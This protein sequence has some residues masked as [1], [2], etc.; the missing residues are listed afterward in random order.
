MP[1]ARSRNV[2]VVIGV[3]VV[4]GLTA[5]KS[6][7]PVAELLDN[8]RVALQKNDPATA[9]VH[10]KTVLQ[11]GENAEAHR[12]LA[13]AYDAMG[14][15]VPAETHA[16][17]A[18]AGGASP[19]SVLPVLA[20]AMRNIGEVKKLV[21]EF[22]GAMLDDPAAR[23]DFAATL[24]EAH[25]SLA[26]IDAAE[27]TM[28][29]VRST[30]VTTPHLETVSARL[31]AAR[32][33]AAG[34]AEQVDRILAAHP[35]FV[36]A[37]ILKADLLVSRGNHADAKRALATVIQLDPLNPQARF[38]LISL[39]MASGEL[40]AAAAGI[41]D[42][43]KV[44]PGDVRWQY[45][46]AVFAFRANEPVKVQD[47][48]QQVLK[49]VPDH[50]PSRLL[51]G[52]NAYSMG[53]YATA[54][55]SIRR[56]LQAY[57]N[58]IYARNLLVATYLRKGQPAKAE[59]AL[60]PALKLAPNDPAVLRAAGEVAFANQ[61]IGEAAAFYEKAL[62]LEKDSAATRTRLAQIRL[63]TG[64]SGR[65]IEELEA[66]AGMDQSQYQA[67]LSLIAA[68]LERREYAKALQAGVA[69][70]RKQPANPL[71][72]TVRAS[73]HLAQQDI[74]KARSSLEQALSLQFNYLPAAR[75]LANLDLG[76]RKPAVA[77][78][79]Y[80][81]ILAR[82]PNN[83][84][85]CIA[86]AELLSN[87]NAPTRDIVALIEKAIRLSPTS[88]AARIA[89]VKLHTRNKDPKAALAAAQAAYEVIVDD[90][91]IVDALGLAQM[92]GGDTDKAVETYKRMA[93]SMPDNPLPLMRL[94]S[95]QYAAKQ[96]DAPIDALRKALAIKP[97]LL[98]AHR[99]I[100]AVQV[101]AGRFDDAVRETRNLQKAKPKEAVGFALEAEMFA[102]QGK[103]IEAAAAYGE[104]LKRQPNVDLVVKQHQSLRSAGKAAE[105]DALATKW[106][107]DNPKD[108][109]LRFHLA[110]VAAQSK[111]HRAAA[112]RFKELLAQQPDNIALLNNLAWVLS[113]ANDPA[114]LTFAERA[115]KQAPTMPE[116]L[117]TYGWVLSNQSQ[118]SDRQRG[119][120]LLK[121]AAANSPQSNEIRMRLGKALKANG[122]KDG[123]RREWQTAANT[124]TGALRNE[125]DQ[126]LREP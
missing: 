34:A 23:A 33:N 109:V 54:E 87:T 93:A 99:E 107:R 110:N 8:A 51:A 86:F 14:Q 70:E 28:A 62:V 81:A 49:V 89:L 59:D 123:A 90:P 115:F 79:R 100:I 68:Y 84:A 43:K 88:A 97:D 67:D 27:R 1:C 58:N 57:P 35:N 103:F 73:I 46:D 29:V 53:A 6:A 45:L 77:K 82:D 48:I 4:I 124:A 3:A 11:R 2:V 10:L 5:C 15:P 114:A 92:A 85:A 83:D 75:V 91:R 36:A 12:L 113:E 7:V 32:G 56:V 61:R 122:D 60:A 37:H 95:A 55:D 94:A 108:S 17:R 13:E 119:I 118:A 9:A 116:V 26:Q 66:A 71:T 120:E 105:A 72:H 106:L 65:A 19:A 69:L 25:L 31:M 39:Q 52:A 47:A 96:I 121:L 78:A 24:T 112:T 74:D 20:R 21:D 76:D 64:E 40:D 80:E 104:G 126:L 42:M 22:G 101:A 44:I 63:S 30:G 38:A 41:L 125:L 50:L 111:D 16:R 98:E 18:L 117:D 102:S